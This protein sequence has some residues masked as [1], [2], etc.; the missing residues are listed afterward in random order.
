MK[1]AAFVAALT[2]GL[3]LSGAAL[4]DDVSVTLQG[5]QARGG[6]VYVSLQTED[7]FMDAA[8]LAQRVAA[9]PAG[10]LT[11][12]FE[13]VPPGRYAVS[14]FHDENGDGQMQVSDA[15]IPIEGWAMTN[16]E[17]LRGEPSFDQ[18]SV[19]IGP[20]GAEI[21]ATMFYW[22]GRIPGY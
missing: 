11:V 15:G 19:E 9:P 7:Q 18:V 14:A 3:S 5:V 16:G 21:S 22:D 13:S 6:V 4:A 2:A 17:T 8:G 20:D 12:V 10:P 1:S